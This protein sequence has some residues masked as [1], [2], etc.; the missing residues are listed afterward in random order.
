MGQ[1]R[2][3]SRRGTAISPNLPLL[4]DV[5]EYRCGAQGLGCRAAVPFAP[6]WAPSEASRATTG[7][8]GQ[9]GCPCLAGRQPFFSPL[10]P[11][12]SVQCC[13][14]RFGCLCLRDARH[15]C[16]R[17]LLWEGFWLGPAS[18]ADGYGH[19]EK[20]WNNA[21]ECLPC[22][23]ALS[24][25]SLTEKTLT[26]GRRLPLRQ[27]APPWLPTALPARDRATTRSAGPCFGRPSA[28]LSRGSSSPPSAV[29]SAR[30]IQIA[31]GPIPGGT[32]LTHQ[33]PSFA[34][35]TPVTAGW[36]AMS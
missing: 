34:C 8:L 36:S 33:G 18:A 12:L 20:F 31:A 7:P 17:Q 30:P 4:H 27:S 21:D 13:V 28:S 23:L 35:A 14:L 11:T 5:G 19:H 15:S 26:W 2:P 10:Y 3:G 29:P 24:Q 25:S 6:H 16:Q 22:R 9:A 32:G 1:L